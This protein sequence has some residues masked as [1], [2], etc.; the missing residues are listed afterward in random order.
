[1]YTYHLKNILE[2]NDYNNGAVIAK[3]KA[4]GCT[5]S[6][7]KD[8]HLNG[9]ISG[10][11]E[12]LIPP[13]APANYLDLIQR[14]DDGFEYRYAGETFNPTS[15]VQR[16]GRIYTTMV[17][18]KRRLCFQAQK[19]KDRALFTWKGKKLENFDVSASQL[20]IAHALRGVVLPFGISPWDSLNVEHP[21][22]DTLPSKMARELKKTVALLLVRGERRLSYKRIWCD[23]IEAPYEDMPTLK[24][25]QDAVAV[26]MLIDY[27]A[28]NSELKGFDQT[29]DGYAITHKSETFSRHDIQCRPLDI[30][31]TF[32]RYASAPPTEG[33]ILEAMEA[34]VIRQVIQ[35][36]PPDEPVLAVHDQL[37]ITPALVP[38]VSDGFDSAIA[39]L[40]QHDQ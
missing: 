19:S 27:P 12:R 4:W 37:Y 20:R 17:S 10:W 13:H 26:A 38:L 25:Y 30:K 3:L 18:D 2:C 22:M 14:L 8:K 16:S 35:S 1:L 15:R 33:N 34:Y 31:T 23:K 36:L 40:A 6:K 5:Y 29:P 32:K 39:K 11:Q 7:S 9:L 21:V 24:G 28:L